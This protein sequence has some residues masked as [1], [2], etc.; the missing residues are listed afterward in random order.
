MKAHILAL[1]IFC[2]IFGFG[3]KGSMFNSEQKK[4]ILSYNNRDY[5]GMK[6]HLDEAEK[7]IRGEDSLIQRAQWFNNYGAYYR[8]IGDYGL[9]VSNFQ[10]AIDVYDKIGADS[11]KAQA[12]YNLGLILKNWE[13]YDL[14]INKLGSALLYYE[15][16]EKRNKIFKVYSVMGN[17]Y[18]QKG[19]FEQSKDYQLKA[20][21][22]C[23]S[24]DDSSKVYHSLGMLYLVNNKPDEGIFY[25]R[26]ERRFK[27]ILG[28]GLAENSAQIGEYF[29]KQDQ[30]DSAEVYF[31]ESLN[32]RKQFGVR[33]KLVPAYLH[34][35]NLFLER[36]NYNEAYKYLNEAFHIADSM[37]LYSSQVNILETQIKIDKELE[38]RDNQ[39]LKYDLLLKVKE[40]AWGEEERKAMD[41]FTVQYDTFLKDEEIEQKK[42][43]LAISKLENEKLVYRNGLLFGGIIIAFIIVGG[44]V[45]FTVVLRQSR[46]E[47]ANQNTQ[48]NENNQLIESLHRE[49]SHR[50]KNYYQMFAGLLKFDLKSTNDPKMQLM[51]KHYIRRVKAMSE[52]HRYLHSEKTISGTVKLDLYLSNLLQIMDMALNTSNNKVK[53]KETFTTIEYNYDKALRLGLVMNEIVSNALEHGFDTQIEGEIQLELVEKGNGLALTIR[54]NGKGYYPN[55][56]TEKDSTGGT[57]IIKNILSSVKGTFEYQN[58]SEGTVILISIPN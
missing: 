18:R 51:L 44:M 34:M 26:Q 22:L 36:E 20:L 19:D 30:L 39:L 38:R 27:Q 53:I 11:S 45:W 54:D 50:T 2:W 47:I 14:A 35:G 43:Q 16:E 31:K 33:S 40:E 29:L 41:R 56:L 32:E 28:S 52:I 5:D 4:A 42:N 1:F 37:K 13:I 23:E 48:L 9:G 17:L 57:G 49:L 3:Q 15:K 25:L 55:L 46:L 24:L 8:K 7:H 6:Y 12:E 21:D 10:D 58:Q